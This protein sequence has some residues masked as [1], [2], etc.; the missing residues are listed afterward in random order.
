MVNFVKWLDLANLDNDEDIA[1][2][3]I[4]YADLFKDAL[5]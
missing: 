4:T 3:L 2:L 5:P 1:K